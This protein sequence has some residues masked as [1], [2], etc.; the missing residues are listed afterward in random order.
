[1]FIQNGAYLCL[2][3]ERFAYNWDTKFQ[4]QINAL[5]FSIYK[6]YV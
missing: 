3:G 1:M 5:F 4:T 2:M 6:L